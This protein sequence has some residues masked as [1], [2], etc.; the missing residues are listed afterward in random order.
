MA[1]DHSHVLRPT[2]DRAKET[3]KSALD[4]ACA[5]DIDDADTAELIRIEEVLAIAN[6]AAKKV[7]SVR[8]RLSE[9]GDSRRDSASS[10]REVEDE[11]GVRWAVFA[12]HPGTATARP[13]VRECFRNGWLAFDSGMETRRIAPIPDGWEAASDETLLELCAKADVAPRRA[14]SAPAEP[15][16]R[17]ELPG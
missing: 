12:V 4:S 1:I 14:R 11:R 10:H 7:V 8:R 6:E 15:P 3:L 9:D 5:A 17:R 2:L 13:T 16:D